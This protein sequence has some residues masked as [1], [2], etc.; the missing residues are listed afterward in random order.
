MPFNTLLER[1]M[2]LS[3][4]VLGAP[5]EIEFAINLHRTDALPARFGFLQVRPMM[6][7][8]ER[9]AVSA[10]D[11]AAADVVVASTNVLG[12]GERSDITDVVFIRPDAFEPSETPLM[13]KELERIN[14]SLVAEGRFY[15]LIGFGRW[16]TSDPPL[17][18]P[19]AWGQISGARVIV[20]A[21]L[22][23]VQPELSQGSHFFHNLLSFQ[24]L[25]LSVEHDGPFEIDWEWME[26]QPVIQSSPHITHVRLDRPVEV[27][28]DGGSG[29]G[30][31]TRNG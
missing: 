11:T 12:N 24:V 15:L 1:L 29:R 17:G 25:Y 9:V 23:D 10:E 20:E 26:R 7:S 4:E 3:E 30:V 16:G 2:V 22:P 5:V 21:T 18:V 27:R 6:V 8:D 31:V 13:A 28:V 14:Q 19:V